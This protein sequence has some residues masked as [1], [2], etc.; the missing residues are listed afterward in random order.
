MT[1]TKEKVVKIAPTVAVES[2][3]VVKVESTKKAEPKKKIVK[4]KTTIVGGYKDTYGNK[5]WESKA[6][7]LEMKLSHPKSIFSLLHAEL[8]GIVTK[9]TKSKTIDVNAL[10]QVPKIDARFPAYILSFIPNGE[11]Y[12]ITEKVLGEKKSWLTKFN[13]TKKPE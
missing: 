5:D 10:L 13:L 1:K 9:G 4:P 3:K 6:K 7:F 12:G 2:D 8:N 11:K